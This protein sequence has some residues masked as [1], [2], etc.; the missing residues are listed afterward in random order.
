MQYRAEA[1]MVPQVLVTS[2]ANLKINTTCPEQVYWKSA[3]IP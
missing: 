3:Q 1:Y 2:H